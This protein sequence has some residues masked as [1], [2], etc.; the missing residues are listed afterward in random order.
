VARLKY[1][2]CLNDEAKTAEEM[3]KNK[4]NTEEYGNWELN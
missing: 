3:N 4:V 1:G 2:P